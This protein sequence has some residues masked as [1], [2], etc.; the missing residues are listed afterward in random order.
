VAAS[1]QLAVFTRRLGILPT[2]ASP[3]AVG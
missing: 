2:V 1:F 3:T